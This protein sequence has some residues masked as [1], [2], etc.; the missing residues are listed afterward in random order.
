MVFLEFPFWLCQT[1]LCDWHY[2]K[3]LET[4]E[5]YSYKSLH[6]IVTIDICKILK[7]WMLMN[8]F[9]RDFAIK[10]QKVFSLWIYLKLFRSSSAGLMFKTETSQRKRWV[11]VT[12]L[13]NCLLT[14]LNS[15][16]DHVCFRP[17]VKHSWSKEW[18]LSS[19]FVL[20]TQLLSPFS[21]Y[22][23]WKLSIFKVNLVWIKNVHKYVLRSF[24]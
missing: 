18:P 21:F 4:F 23:L 2:E 3:Y 7:K 16:V 17:P 15:M 9:I 6:K 20:L 11:F 14:N 8:K 5:S 24:K 13:N 12:Y 19:H 22:L 1:E 10:T